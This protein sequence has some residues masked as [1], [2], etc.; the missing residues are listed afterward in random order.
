VLAVARQFFIFSSQR[1]HFCR[2]LSIHC[3]PKLF[4]EPV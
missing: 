4:D 1:S 2:A 3:I